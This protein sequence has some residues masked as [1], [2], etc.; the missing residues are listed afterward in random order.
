VS[1]ADPAG[2]AAAASEPAAGRGRR[3]WSGWGTWRRSRPFWGGVLL[4]A[5]GAEL[6]LIPLPMHSMGLILHIGTG[7]VLGILI[8]ALLIVCALLIW[9]NPG[10]RMFY[11]IVGVLVSIAALIATNLGG[12]LFGTLLGV[13]G[14]SLAFAWMPA[15]DVAEPA[16]LP[17]GRPG[18]RAGRHDASLTG[19]SLVLGK[20]GGRPS[21]G[22]GDDAGSATPAAGSA[23]G[24]AG[25]S[26]PGGED[27][28]RDHRPGAGPGSAAGADGL[29]LPALPMQNNSDTERG[30]GGGTMYRG[31]P[32]LPLV[33]GLVAGIL[34]AGSASAPSG[35][36]TG[37]AAAAT[38]RPH[39][40]AAPRPTPSPSASCPSPSPSPT[41]SGPAPTGSPSPD[42]TAS[43]SRGPG[44]VKK[45]EKVARK[46]A[47]P[48][49]V[50]LAAVP[51]N[52]TANTAT[53]TG[54]S[55][56]GVA[57]V[58]TAGGPQKMLKFSMSGLNL[59]GDDDLTVT[60]GG[61]TLSIRAS[62]LNFTGNVTL[63][64]TKIHGDL[65]GIPLTF[66]P[67]SPP[68]VVLPEM[69]FTHVT[70]YQPFTSADSLQ[71]GGL[72]ITSR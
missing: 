56:D 36:P 15:P 33:L 70:T 69:V 8:G 26:A 53:L 6:L 35:C 45:P 9:F 20:P 4:A 68:P 12:F 21:A 62:S 14:G 18:R 61:R 72:L 39:P 64:C 50:V 16:G 10:Q 65:L 47:A 54:L 34:H 3:A 59:S 19:L 44:P 30:R 13:L 1:P 24:V 32:V 37:P 41:A 29:T 22:P 25:G 67:Q 57:T 42:P 55:F 71:I 66:T 7:G 5:A 60:E 27:R 2:L 11:S 17:R 51:S 40:T 52:I 43:G 38:A 63:L 28:A 49:G 23:A 48:G 31:L 58:P 46:A